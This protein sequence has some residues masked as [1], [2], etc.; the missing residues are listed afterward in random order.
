MECYGQTH[1]ITA[2][3]VP[4]IPAQLLQDASRMVRPCGQLKR[5]LR[6]KTAVMPLHKFLS[7]YYSKK[8]RHVPTHMQAH[9]KMSNLPSANQH[10]VFANHLS[11]EGGEE[12]CAYAPAELY[13]EKYVPPVMWSPSD[14]NLD[15]LPTSDFNL[16]LLPTTSAQPQFKWSMDQ[17]MEQLTYIEATDPQNLSDPVD[18]GGISP[19]KHKSLGTWEDDGVSA[20]L[21]DTPSML[22]SREKEIYR[23]PLFPELDFRDFLDSP[24]PQIVEQEV[25]EPWFPVQNTH[26]DLHT[27]PAVDLDQAAIGLDNQV[28]TETTT[29]TMDVVE[30][31][32]VPWD[33]DPCWNWS[34][35]QWGYPDLE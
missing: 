19:T 2:R 9:F 26:G 31:Q 13:E 7:R 28:T 23:D 12:L 20:V 3:V 21:A 34:E 33:Q 25:V 5:M 16:D 30:E 24:A 32:Y 35:V 11:L 29:Y 14:F 18:V 22:Q 6:M 15:L 8:N 4:R 27:P 17:T 1:D 10:L